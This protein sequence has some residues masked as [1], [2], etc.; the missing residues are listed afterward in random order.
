[1]HNHQNDDECDSIHYE[2]TYNQIPNRFILITTQL[3]CVCVC[4]GSMKG[5]AFSLF[6]TFYSQSSD[7]L[8]YQVCV[9]VCVAMKNTLKVSGESASVHTPKKIHAKIHPG[10]V[11]EGAGSSKHVITIKWLLFHERRMIE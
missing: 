5:R 6:T 11:A 2:R 7:E 8:Q 1:M 10:N 9:C 3:W 4:V